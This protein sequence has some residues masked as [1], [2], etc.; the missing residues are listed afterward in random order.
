[1]TETRRRRLSG[2][3]TPTSDTGLH[4]GS[5]SCPPSGVPQELPFHAGSGLQTR[6]RR[7]L[8]LG[9]CSPP[10]YPCKQ[11]KA[12]LLENGARH[13]AV[14]PSCAAQLWPHTRAAQMQVFPSG[15][16][17]RYRHSTGQAP[18]VGHPSLLSCHFHETPLG[19]PKCRRSFLRGILAGGEGKG[20]S[21]LVW[22]EVLP[23]VLLLCLP[24][25][26]R[27]FLGKQSLHFP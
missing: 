18:R 26:R 15:Q 13:R 16:R 22:E 11:Q 3:L 10:A 14:A 23:W 9:L 20:E 25:R 21:H 2:S 19:G 27:L 4:P 6:T 8:L 1:M 17:G 5:G 12:R 7:T 24:Q